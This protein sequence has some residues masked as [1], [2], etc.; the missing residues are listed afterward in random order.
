MNNFKVDGVKLKIEYFENGLIQ[1]FMAE[2]TNSF[3]EILGFISYSIYNN[4]REK[5]ITVLEKIYRRS[6]I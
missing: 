3:K 2:C 1:E 5:V 4:K 6:K